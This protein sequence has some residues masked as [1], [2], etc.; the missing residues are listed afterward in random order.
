MRNKEK[1]DR[2][3]LRHTNNHVF[4]SSMTGISIVLVLSLAFNLD[5][6]ILT[7]LWGIMLGGVLF[8]FT[9]IIALAHYIRHGEME[10]EFDKTLAK[11]FD[12]HEGRIKDLEKKVEELEK[13]RRH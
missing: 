3:I 13:L 7:I 10:L 5:V 12:N 1:I 2:S 11:G 9:N 6:N 8:A 4:H